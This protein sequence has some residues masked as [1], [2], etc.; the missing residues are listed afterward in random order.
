M[1]MMMMMMFQK[2]SRNALCKRLGIPECILLVTQR[3]TK[4]PLLIQPIIKTTRGIWQHTA[5]LICLTKN[6]FITVFAVFCKKFTVVIVAIVKKYYRLSSCDFF[7]TSGHR[8]LRHVPCRGHSH[9]SVTGASR[10]LDR[11]CGT[12]CGLRSDGKTLLLNII[13]GY[14]RRICSFRLR[15]IATFLLKCAGYK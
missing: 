7:V 9:R 10:Q 5:L 2:C 6:T 13:G 12:A 15:R 14:W 1:M 3:V 4:Y 8:T 11:G